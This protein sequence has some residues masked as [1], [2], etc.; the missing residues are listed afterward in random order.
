MYL[1]PELIVSC[2]V[3]IVASI[4]RAVQVQICAANVRLT[5]MS[6]EYELMKFFVGKISVSVSSMV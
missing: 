2:Y 3:V 5:E 6:C 1:Q 4:Q